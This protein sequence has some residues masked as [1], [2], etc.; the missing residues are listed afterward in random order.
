[1]DGKD[2]SDEV[3]DGNKEHTIENRKTG[4]PCYNVP[5]RLAELCSHSSIL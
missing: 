1:M 2:H 4:Y 3:L 5:K